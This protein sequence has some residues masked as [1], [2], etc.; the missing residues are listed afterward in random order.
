MKRPVFMF[1]SVTSRTALTVNSDSNNCYGHNGRYLRHV[2]FN[3]F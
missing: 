2:I 1:I 3:K